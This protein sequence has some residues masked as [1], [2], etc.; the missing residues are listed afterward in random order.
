MSISGHFYKIVIIFAS[1]E[2]YKTY[3]ILQD[4]DDGKLYFKSRTV[5]EFSLIRVE[6]NSN[7]RSGNRI[8]PSKLWAQRLRIAVSV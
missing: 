1:N 5:T 6:T 4:S 3:A 7:K 2:E 8:N